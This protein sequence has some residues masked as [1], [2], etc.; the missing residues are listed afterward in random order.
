MF[1][2]KRGGQKVSADAFFDGL[3]ED[4]IDAG[5]NA[6]I[7]DVHAKAASVVDPETGRHPFVFADRVGKDQIVIRTTGSPAFARVLEDRLGLSD[8]EVER[9]DASFS[10]TPYVYLAHATE[11]KGIVRPLAEGLMRRGIEVWFDEWEISAGD[12]LRRKMEAGLDACTHFVVMLSPTSI[13]KQWVAEELDVGLLRAVEGSARFVG[14]R[15]GLDVDDLSAF[16]RT[17]LCPKYEPD[18]G[19]IDTVAAS[20]YGVSRKPARGAAPRYVRITPLM[21]AW[22]TSAVAVAEHFIRTSRNAQPHDP[23]S[24]YEWLANATK[25][26]ERDVR[27]GVADLRDAGLLDVQIFLGGDARIAAKA[28][29]FAEFDER[30]MD[31]NPR[32]DAR[33]LA[34]YLSGGA[35]DQ[36][37]LACEQVAAA[38]EWPARRFNPAVCILSRARAVKERSVLGGSEFHPMYIIVQDAVERFTD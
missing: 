19:G 17:R 2:F 23:M 3:K 15:Y 8:G 6:L 11:D 22:S 26:P 32:E 16:L 38:L 9:T 31:W 14:V 12:S 1:E 29:L 13:R 37:I 36:R 35:S 30:F 24:T 10:G 34:N 18:E 5:M 21:D 20:I 25:L 28:A 27:A 7:E 4:V 33:A